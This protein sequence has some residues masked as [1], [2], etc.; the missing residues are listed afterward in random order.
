MEVADSKAYTVHI[1]PDQNLQE[2][3][4]TVESLPDGHVIL[5]APNGSRVLRSV[6]A[7]RLVRRTVSPEGAVAIVSPDPEIQ[8]SGRLAGLNV[9]Q[10][11]TQ[12]SHAIAAGN[13][14]PR[15]A[16]LGTA[17]VA[18]A[19]ATG[20]GIICLLLAT[21]VFGTWTEVVLEPMS[22][23]VEGTLDLGLSYE[24]PVQP[25]QISVR[26][27]AKVVEINHQIETTGVL[28][29]VERQS[30]GV[31]TLAN[32]RDQ[33]ITIPAGTSLWSESGVRFFINAAVDLPA[34]VNSKVRVNVIAEEPGESANLPRLSIT[35]VDDR[36]AEHVSVFNE[37]ATEG[38]GL[39]SVKIVAEADMASLRS[40]VL[41]MARDDAITEIASTK[42]AD[43][44]A[45][46]AL[47]R[48][49]VVDE[50]FS[51]K[52]GEESKKLHVSS[53]IL[54]R[55]PLVSSFELQ[56]AVSDLW[57]E[58]LPVGW[59]IKPSSVELIETTPRIEEESIQL[60]V[61]SR[62]RA[63]RDI[64]DSEVV[65]TVRLKPAV[66]A[67]EALMDKFPLA[68]PPLVSVYPSWPGISLRVNVHIKDDGASQ[69]VQNAQS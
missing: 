64:M 58:N 6:A 33:A 59:S 19:G 13:Y 47:S 50:Q 45:I 56:Q 49:S 62:G 1:E 5:L 54:V 8:A 36:F 46:V 21:F 20:L 57:N 17:G 52:L 55:T 24:L 4:S 39:F 44:L 28:H 22:R 43:T 16:G 27:H 42:D 61:A 53:K 26:E 10:S 30:R 15:G 35:K 60:T 51:H 67:R 63:A 18:I 12:A 34:S 29:Q 69:Q 40:R 2:I 37:Q 3:R 25:G 66:E 41:E 9:H 7:M 38:G 32:R 11:F 31:V 48:L 23:Q 14:G 65:S 68:S